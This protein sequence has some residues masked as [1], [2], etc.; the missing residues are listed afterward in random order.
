MNLTDTIKRYHIAAYLLPI[1]FFLGGCRTSDIS[2][3]QGLLSIQVDREYIHVKGTTV[4]K[5]SDNFG[6]LFL[7]RKVIRLASGENVV[8]ESARTDDLY[9]FNLPFMK[10]IMIVFD[11]RDAVTV[12]MKSNL[13]LIQLVLADGSIL[14]MA[15]EQ[16]DDQRLA[17]VYG[18]SNHS[19]RKMLKELDPEAAKRPLIKHVRRLP[20]DQHAILSHWTVQKIQLIPL[21]VPVSYF[22]GPSLI[23]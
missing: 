10:T 3:Q 6:N 5:K 15:V 21:V 11:A 13:R 17:F 19:F 20:S 18:M 16:F 8:Y 12:Y 7:V 14:N 9:E 23:F 1:L 22:F 2:Y 4:A